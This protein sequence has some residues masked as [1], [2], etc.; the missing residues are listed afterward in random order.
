MTTTTTKTCS[1]QTPVLKEGSLYR[2]KVPARHS[3]YE[4]TLTGEEATATGRR[5]IYPKQ[6]FYEPGTVLLYLGVLETKV[7]ADEDYR[8]QY[9]HGFLDPDAHVVGIWQVWQVLRANQDSDTFE[10]VK[11]QK[12]LPS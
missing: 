1:E 10:T 11:Q 3:F 8:P 2:L 5:F 6:F 4:Q 12:T 7:S 9:F